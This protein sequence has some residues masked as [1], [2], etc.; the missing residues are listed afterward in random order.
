MAT[1]VY[2]NGKM[3]TLPG[4]YSTI[5]SGD[6][7]ATRNL[8]YGTVLL[9]D[10]GVY[11]AGF[12]GGSG[13]NGA[14]KQGLDAV[15]S[16]TDLP[17]FREFVK[18]GL[19]WKAAEALFTP[20]PYNP[21]AVG[22]SNLLYVRACTTTPATMTFAPTGGGANGGNIVIKTIDEGLNANGVLDGEYLKFG[23][24]FTV[25]PGTDDP[26][27]F[28]MQFWRGTYT[29][30][31]TDPVTGVVMSFDELTVAQSDPILIC[32]SPE[33]TNLAEL[34]QWCE[35][36]D[37]FGARFILDT[38]TEIKGDGTVD[39]DDLTDNAGYKVATGATEDYKSTDIDDVLNQIQDLDYNI[40]FTDQIGE[41]GA[42]SI[43][44]KVISHRNNQAKFDKFVF[45]GAYPNKEKYDDS[46]AMARFFNSAWVACVHGGIGTASDLVATKVRWW[47]VFYNLCQVIG[48]VSGKPPYVPAT[49]KTIGG[50]KLQHIP[51]EK[52]MEKAVKAG[53]IIVYPNPYLRRFVIL[54]AV[55]TLQDSQLL[56]NKKG[57]SFSLQFMRILAQL[58]KECVVNAEID[59]MGDEN[60]VNINTLSKGALETWTI[61]FLQQ[62]VATEN[63]DN[64]ITRFQNVVAT[65][66]DD[67]YKV[68][69]EVVVNNEVTK[70]FFTGFLL[71]N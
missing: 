55:T 63:Q 49:N 42:G 23:Y 33:C 64:L 6:N 17:S 61:N 16:F 39:S 69:Y 45:V 57:D 13:I 65:K 25:I 60:G 58:N 20:D 8:D 14:G 51:S 50:D 53:L 32:Q 11:G 19:F 31:W 1:S 2:F 10:T 28:V 66:V 46:L 7:S 36:D 21:D 68:T 56:F 4:I 29:G 30:E 71:R 3:R 70:V 44:L 48:R 15:Y 47:G 52:E 35:T 59:L 62:R 22:I 27:A 12:G 34:V 54:Q 67:Y 24:A 26:N 37:N 41:N 9:I 43:N 40:V 5:T 18:G 38:S